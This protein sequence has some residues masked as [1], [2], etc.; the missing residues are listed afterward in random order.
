MT[1]I[2]IYD[3]FAHIQ[4]IGTG[5]NIELPL[6]VRTD[7]ITVRD[8]YDKLQQY[9]LTE[10][11]QITMGSDYSSKPGPTIQVYKGQKEYTGKLV[12]YTDDIVILSTG[13]KLD[14]IRK[15]DSFII[16]KVTS[17][18]QLHDE[19]VYHIT[20]L[21]DNLRWSTTGT[22]VILKDILTLTI[23]GQIYNSLDTSFIGKVNLISGKVYQQYS[24]HS[25]PRRMALMAATPR[26]DTNMGQMLEDYHVYN[27]GQWDLKNEIETVILD[28]MSVPTEK[29]YIHYTNTETTSFGY[30]FVADRYIPSCPIHVYGDQGMFI[31]TANITQLMSSDIGELIVGVSEMVQCKTVVTSNTIE[32]ETKDNEKVTQTSDT[33]TID[34]NNG[35]EGEVQIK[36][37][38]YIG[39]RVIS[40]IYPEEYK[41]E[42]G[43][44]IWTIRIDAGLSHDIFTVS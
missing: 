12:R 32:K 18:I 6:G 35:T 26:D 13:E 27:L 3:R 34:T 23:K 9:T 10:G 38:H 40:N 39:D 1:S 8:M 2:T 29:V 37:K 31:G 25:Q 7:S 15:Y 41:R 42:K 19:I 17:L 36:V 22:A 4:R 5:A 16:P 43:Y 11:K 30:E 33:I 20:Y 28:T 14:T 21:T 24:Q 44:I